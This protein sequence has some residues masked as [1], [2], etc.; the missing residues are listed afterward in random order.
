MTTEVDRN[1]TYSHGEILAIPVAASALIPAG[2]LVCTNTDGFAVPAADA[3]GY[4]FEGVATERVDNADGE[5]GDLAVI[6]LRRD[7]FRFAAHPCVAQDDMSGRCCVYEN[8]T[9]CSAAMTAHAVFCGRVS[10]VVSPAC[11]DVDVFLSV[12]GGRSMHEDACTTTTHAGTTT[13][14]T[15]PS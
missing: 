11:V 14:T 5:D 2:T 15:E 4:V 7:R 13:T 3:A 1:T 9:V 12:L 6:V 8:D 10:R